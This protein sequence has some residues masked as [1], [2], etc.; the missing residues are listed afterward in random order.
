MKRENAQKDLKWHIPGAGVLGKKRKYEKQD[1]KDQTMATAVTE[2][3]HA[4][5]TAVKE[6]ENAAHAYQVLTDNLR[7]AIAAK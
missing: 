2:A 4:T 6:A 1:D 3:Q 7:A 5:A